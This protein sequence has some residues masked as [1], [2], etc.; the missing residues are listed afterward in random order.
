MSRATEQCPRKMAAVMASTFSRRSTLLLRL[1]ASFGTASG[2]GR[3]SR[4]EAGLGL[5]L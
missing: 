1:S 2:F 5:E 3:R 4:G